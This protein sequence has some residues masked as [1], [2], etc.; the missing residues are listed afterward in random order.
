MKIKLLLWSGVM[1]GAMLACNMERIL[2][3]SLPT[4]TSPVQVIP[5]TP[6]PLPSPTQP[7]TPV[8]AARIEK[9]DQAFWLGDWETA[10]HEY[11][12][13]LESSTD[14]ELEAAA[15][16]GLGRTYYQDGN[17]S[18]ALS[19]L[20]TALNS[21]PNSSHRAALF[22]TLGETYS[23][24]GNPAEAAAAYQEYLNLRPGLID[25][26]LQDWIGDAR[27]DAGDYQGAITAYLQ[28]IQAA[29]L[30][31][32][33]TKQIKIGKAYAA[34]DDHTTAIVTFEDVFNRTQNDFTKA[35]L[36]YLIGQSYTA[37]NRSDQAFLSYQTNVA[38]Y[39]LSYYAYLSLVELVEAGE[40]VSELD[41][42][43]VDYFA[44][45][46]GVAIQAFDRYLDQNPEHDDTAHY[47]K[48]LAYQSLG[49]YDEAIQEWKEMI[50][51]HLND[52]HWADGY[53]ETAFTQWFYQ[54]EFEDAIKTYLEFVDRSPLHPKAA[55]YLYYAGRT[56]E[57]NND[58]NQAAKIWQRVGTQFSTSEWAFDSLFQAGIARFRLREFD[59]AQENFQT[60]LGIAA[61]P[62]DQAAAYFWLGKTHA[63]K[64]DPD[65][66]RGAWQQAVSVDPTGYYSER[67][68]DITAGLAPFTPPPAYSI[69]IDLQAE[70]L[71]AE[72]WLR[73]A[74]AIPDTTDL[75]G[76]GSLLANAGFI[77]ATELWNLGLYNDARLEFENL[78]SVVSHDPELTYR[79]ANYLIDIGLYR[80]GIIAARQVLTLAGMDDARTMSA[81]AYF[82]FLRFG[83]YFNEI[84]IPAAEKYSFHPLF[85]YSVMRQESLFEGFVTSTAGARGLMQIIPDTGEYIF[86][87][88]GWPANYTSDDLYRPL[89]SIN[90]G[91][92]YL[93]DQR[94][95]FDNN[96]SA[97]LAA[98]N[99]GPGNAAS[100]LK[101]AP[102]DPDLFLEVIRFAETRRY[103]RSIYEIYTIYKN[104]YGVE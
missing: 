24:M 97:A 71:Q 2:D 48:G 35:Q 92:D 16:L 58:L 88:S 23:A 62:G 102:D 78:R 19:H 75:N 41:R 68:K 83:V 54:N 65:S 98:Y 34:Q 74:F 89:V 27:Y 80:S 31:D 5:P 49:S 22:F 63:A 70:K 64:G 60:G 9:G 15:W 44:G 104:L 33:L 1:A 39:P 50:D 12:L 91:A 26:Y 66:A 28:S 25:A 67:A 87:N 55:E 47:Y 3:P 90:Y 82:N 45:Q 85:L 29:S 37:I 101:L 81:P 36:L 59:K 20:T 6:T 18:Q 51:D 95:Y 72:I 42:G 94:G 57:R 86:V 76:P 69:N 99:G 30:D 11:T 73:A 8:P 100:W 40:P 56:A 61:S 10:I 32:G 46:Y 77:R 13:A 79:L 96:L 43:L 103:L 21:F 17:Y 7:P 14:A 52:G 38:N 4:S 84:V 53:D 93:S